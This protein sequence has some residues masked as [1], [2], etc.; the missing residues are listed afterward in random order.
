MGNET[1]AASAGSNSP[2][3]PSASRALRIWPAMFLVALMVIT[4][5]VP[6]F[7][8]GGLAK[9]WMFAMMGP[10]VCCLLLVIWWL[11]ASRA[12]WKERVFGFL[13]LAAV[14]AIT[15]ALVEPL[16]RGPD[17]IYIT[18]PMGFTAFVAGATL[19]RNRRPL[20]RTGAVLLLAAAGFGFSVLLRNGGMSGE[21]QLTLHW[22]WAPTPEQQ[23]LAARTTSSAAPKPN[24]PSNLALANPE[25]PDIRGADRSDSCHGP[26]IATNWSEHRPRQLWKVPVGP[27]WSS[28][29]VAGNLLFTQ[30]QRG[31]RETVVCY[32]AATGREIWNHQYEARLED[33]MGG[34][35]PRA[36]PTLANGGLF[37][38]GATGMI[39]RLNLATGDMVWQKDLKEVARREAPMWGFAGSPLVI[40]SNAIVWAGGKDGKGLLAFD[41]ETGALRWSAATGDHT[42]ASPQLNTIAGEELV[43]M[44]SNDGL[45]LVEPVTGK[46]RLNYEWK[47]SGYRALQPRVVGDDTLLLGTPLNVGNS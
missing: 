6:A 39:L 35:G 16:M 43:L 40:G 24:M 19:F 2:V 42:Y 41:A 23:M 12:T 8:E 29:A 10:M 37:V 47:F 44:L 13:G 15:M 14:F 18:L 1:E 26:M 27:G 20:A 28:F 30:E 32:D 4:R 45:V 11:A 22:R 7:L 21:Y 9:Y 33:P 38:T 31:P 5:F 25:L 34:P 3:R 36:T 46:V 17:T